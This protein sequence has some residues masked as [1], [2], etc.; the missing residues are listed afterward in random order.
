VWFYTHWSGTNIQDVVRNALAKKWRWDDESYLARIVFDELTKSEHGEETGFGISTHMQDN[1]HD[2]VVVDVPR[3]MVLIVP[4]SVLVDMRL[5]EHT[6]EFDR[7]TFHEFVALKV[8][9]V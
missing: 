4:E 1:E 8:E 9:K 5:P 2:I 7:W 3:Q 6:A